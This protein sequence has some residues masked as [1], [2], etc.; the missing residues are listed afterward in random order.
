MQTDNQES[1]SILPNQIEFEEQT[2][3]LLEFSTR[4][5]AK[6]TMLFIAFDSQVSDINNQQNN[7]ALA[8]ISERLLSKARE[9]DIYAHLD[10]MNFANLSIETSG[11][12]AEVL[13]EK[14]K[15]ELAE[16]IQLSDGSSIKLNAKIGIAHF[17]AHG[18]SYQ[19]L[20]DHAHKS[21]LYG[22]NNT[23]YKTS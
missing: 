9:S 10:G 11:Q 5:D 4:T 23:S 16:A 20:L 3:E 19:A 12:H 8:A 13:V 2:K 6:A 15:N 14:L 7:L 18:D 22:L 17:P 1:G 21:I